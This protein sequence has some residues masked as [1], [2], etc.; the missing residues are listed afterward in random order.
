V[1][2]RSLLSPEDRA[3]IVW[4]TLSPLESD[5]D[6]G[7]ISLAPSQHRSLLKDGTTRAPE[8]RRAVQ[9]IIRTYGASGAWVVAHGAA[10]R[11]APSLIRTGLPMH[12]TVHDDPAW[13]YALL[14]RRYLPLAPLLERDLGRSL[15][16]ARSVDVVSESMARRYRRRHGVES[17][18]VHRGLVGRVPPAPEYDRTNGVSVAVLGS[19]YG[20]R[21]MSVLAKALALVARSLQIP[22]RLTVIGGVDEARVREI[23]P[24]GVALNVTGHL[25]EFHGINILRKT[26]LLYLSYPFGWRGAVLRTTSFPTK[27]ST[28]VMAA[29]PLVL[30]MPRE[31]SV[32][33]LGASTPYATLWDSDDPERGADI[34]TRLWRDPRSA[35]SFHDSA[36]SLR[37]QHFDLARNRSTLIGALNRLPGGPATHPTSAGRRLASPRPYGG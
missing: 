19:T 15:R 16:G 26:F 28:Y 35:A 6:R 13:A 25:D 14:T 31:S 27:L 37:A 29:R 17:L 2:L 11:L 36:D 21:Q 8:L 24:P 22:T 10:V 12:L 30:H 7:L 33:F 32:A 3:R 23:S 4:V 34:I 20:Y 1:I 18:I 9:T 5:D